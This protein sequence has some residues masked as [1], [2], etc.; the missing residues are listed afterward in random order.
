MILTWRGTLNAYLGNHN[1][2]AVFGFGLILL[3]HIEDPWHFT[4]YIE[5]MSSILCTCFEGI[6]AMESL[7]TLLV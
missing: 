4:S 6:L 2:T 1:S 3:N 7:L 5:I